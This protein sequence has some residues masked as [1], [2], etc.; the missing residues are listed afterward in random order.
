MT[1]TD[2]VKQ[3]YANFASGNVPAALALFDPAIEWYEC[4]GMPFIKEDGYFTGPDLSSPMCSC[5][6]RWCMTIS[7]W[8]FQT[9]P[10]SGR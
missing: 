1:N 3:L 8:K 6:F 9:P 5:S 4:S 2:L 10:I 7:T